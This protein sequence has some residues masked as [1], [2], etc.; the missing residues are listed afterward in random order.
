VNKGKA[1]AVVSGGLDSV[2]MA[3]E[4]DSMG[5][6]VDVVSF[7]Y[8]QRHKKE[9]KFARMLCAEQDWRHDVVDLTNLTHLISNSALTSDHK[10][11]EGN[12]IIDVPEGH[13][14]EDTMSAT[15]VPNRNMIMI[16]IACGIAVNR[17]AKTVGL[18]VHGGDHFIY[19]DCR[20]DFIF[21]MGTAMLQGNQGFHSFVAGDLDEV[22]EVDGR[23]YATYARPIETPFLEKTKADIAFRALELGVPLHMTWSCYK[24]GENHCG[25]CGTCIERLEAIG[26]ALTQYTTVYGYT[27]EDE[28]V[29]DDDEYWKVVVAQR[30]AE[31]EKMAAA[32]KEL[33]N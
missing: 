29:Y 20:P 26:E 15:V 3:C 27:I 24:G 23:T 19:P 9:L 22:L 21:T 18:G 8:G 25:R 30:T 33:N 31:E 14:A 13:Y 10:H 28:T 16:A 12:D 6:Q 4:L 2:T 17:K 11:A 1:I 7:D 32:M 5:Y